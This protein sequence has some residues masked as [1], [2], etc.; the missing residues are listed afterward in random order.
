M[1]FNSLGHDD[2]VKVK[3]QQLRIIFRVLNYKSYSLAF[4]G[5]IYQLPFLIQ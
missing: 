2:P 1:V 4:W 5:N 3:V